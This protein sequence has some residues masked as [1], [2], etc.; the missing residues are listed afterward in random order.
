[1]NDVMLVYGGTRAGISNRTQEMSWQ[2]TP[3]AENIVNAYEQ[4]I[5]NCQT[6]DELL[7]VLFDMKI[8]DINI[9][10]SRGYVYLSGCMATEISLLR[11]IDPTSCVDMWNV[12]TRGMGLRVKAAELVLAEYIEDVRKRMYGIK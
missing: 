2:L 1:M 8:C 10:G 4:D 9:V 11:G 3:V 12:V 5:D 6:V 7:D